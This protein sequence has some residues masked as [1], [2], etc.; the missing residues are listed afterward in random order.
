MWASPM[1]VLP[2]LGLCGFDDPQ[3]GSVFHR[4]TGVHELGLAEDCAA[5]LVAECL[6]A[7]QRSVPDGADESLLNV[8]YVDYSKTGGSVS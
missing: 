8:H 4:S 3:G 7:N 2:A 1:P 5:G 6:Q